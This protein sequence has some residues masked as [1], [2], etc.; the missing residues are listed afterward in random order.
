M[1]KVNYR[2]TVATNDT[3]TRIGFYGMIPPEI[4]TSKIRV[5]AIFT[6][7][8]IDRRIPMQVTC[9][10]S[11]SGT[12]V[13][14]VTEVELPYVF[15]NSPRG[16]VELTFS[17][18]YGVQ[19]Q[20]L[21]NETFSF[22]KELFA[23][24]EEEVKKNNVAFAGYSV[25]LPFMLAKHYFKEGRSFD[26]AKRAANREI[27]A[28]TGRGYSPRQGNT[29]YFAQMYQEYAQKEDEKKDENNTILFLSERKPEA[30]GNLMLV[31]GFFDTDPTVNVTEFINTKTVDK[32]SKEELEECA[33]LCAQ[34]KVIVLEDFYPQLH[35]L[36]IRR[37]TKVVQLWH[38]CG[39]FKTFGFSRMGLPGGVE[40]SSMNHRNYDVSCVSSEAIR[41]IYAEAFGIPTHR[42]QALGVP[43]TDMLFD[44]EYKR[45]KR[46]ELYDKYPSFKDAK[47]VL[48][49]PTFRGDGNKDAYY[50]MDKFDVNTFM[51]SMPEDVILII[52]QHPFVKN[53]ADVD[54]K[55]K[56]RVFDLSENEHINNLL[57]ITDL[58][59]T[60]YSSSIFEA[61]ILEVPTIHYAFDEEEYMASRDFY[62]SLE[63][64]AVGPICHEFQALCDTVRRFVKQKDK[65]E[66]ISKAK[67]ERFQREF[68]SGLDGKSTARIYRYIKQELLKN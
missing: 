34:A 51:E 4:D 14:G 42:V 62:T 8:A 16:Q 57:L 15:Y 20:R 17:I 63:R 54:E 31:K 26:K 39:A 7:K 58:M 52:K 33:K 35:K 64:I 56:N 21:D 24:E 13:I 36:H 55:W 3:T 6:Q 2:V 44:W 25:A 12:Q 9:D 11:E 1:K 19:E 5:Q 30:E 65:Q 41:G 61:V 50:P 67:V 10:R 48:F 28:K 18:W 49:A 47:I 40:Q 43:R 27:Y 68:L 38:A 22:D 59:I 45:N 60:D 29:D 37:D 53:K 66:F 46:S 23:R 32:L